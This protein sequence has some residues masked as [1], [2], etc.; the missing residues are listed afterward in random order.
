MVRNFSR[1]LMACFLCMALIVTYAIPASVFAEDAASAG[2]SHVSS[3]GE[4]KYFDENGNEVGAND[5]WKV[6]TQAVARP[7][8]GAPD[9]YD[10]TFETTT[11]DGVKKVNA[12]A[13]ASTVLVFDVSSSMEER[14]GGQKRM[15]AAK[16]AA[17]NFLESFVSGAEQSQRL[18]QIVVFGTN[19]KVLTGSWINANNNGTVSAEA[20]AAIDAVDTEFTY[21]LQT[22]TTDETYIETRKD[23]KIGEKT[24]WRCSDSNCSNHNWHDGDVPEYCTHTVDDATFT[25]HS[26]GFLNMGTRYKCDY[27]GED[28][29]DKSEK[30]S[31]HHYRDVQVQTI[32]TQVVDVKENQWRCTFDGCPYNEWQSGDPDED[33]YWDWGWEYYYTHTHEIPVYSTYYDT[34]GTN[35]EGGLTLA[36][37]LIKTGLD[38]QAL[39]GSSS[40]IVITDGQPTN[41]NYKKN[42]DYSSTLILGEP[43][44]GEC[45]NECDVKNIPNLVKEIQDMNS[46]NVYATVY[47]YDSKLKVY[48][49]DAWQF[50]WWE[51]DPIKTYNSVANWL[52]ETGVDGAYSAANAGQLNEKFRNITSEIEE[53][54]PTSAV[55]ASA[56][57]DN[58]VKY[59]S[60]TGVTTAVDA[61]SRKTLVN[62]APVEGTVN[63]DKSKTYTATF[64]V[65]LNTKAENFPE[66]TNIPVASG[67]SL[68]F[69]YGTDNVVRTVSIDMPEFT[70]TIPEVAYSIEYYKMSKTTGE[71]ELVERDTDTGN[72]K[73][74]TTINVPEGYATKYDNAN[75][76][77]YELA[78]AKDMPEGAAN[79]IDLKLTEGTNKLTLYYTPIKTDVT[80][81][82]YYTTKNTDKNNNITVTENVK[83]A[84]S[85]K[86]AGTFYVGDSFTATEQTSYNG[87]PYTKKSG[88]ATIS[89]L[90][91]NGNEI[92]LYYTGEK[93]DR[94]EASFIG[95]A[96]YDLGQYVVNKTT[97]RY[98]IIYPAAQAQE[99]YNQKKMHAYDTATF[100]LVEHGKE[101]YT[102]AKTVNATSDVTV[103]AAGT[104]LTM[105]MVAGENTMTAVFHKAPVDNRT[106]ASV[107]VVHHYELHETKIVD[108]EVVNTTYKDQG[109]NKVEWLQGY[110]VGEFFTPEE[111]LTYDGGEGNGTV[112]YTAAPGNAAKL[113]STE[114]KTSDAVVDLYYTANVAPATTTVTVEHRY[115]DKVWATDAETGENEK[116]DRENESLAKTVNF[117]AEGVL[118]V[119]YK[120]T[121]P[122]IGEAGY[123]VEAGHHELVLAAGDDNKIVINYYKDSDERA[124]SDMKVQHIYINHNTAVKDG[125]VQVIDITS[126]A[127]YNEA[128]DYYTGKNKD[129]Y[130]V[131]PVTTYDGETYSLTKVGDDKYTGE[132]MLKGKFKPGTN[133][134]I[135]LTYER[136]SSSLVEGVL[137]IW[138]NLIDKFGYI[139]DD[140]KYAY[141]YY[142]GTNAED[143]SRHYSDEMVASHIITAKGI[144]VFRPGETTAIDVPAKVYV[145][146]QFTPDLPETYEYEGTTY[147]YLGGQSTFTAEPALRMVRSVDGDAT[148]ADDANIIRYGYTDDLGQKDITIVKHFKTTTYDVA[149]EVSVSNTSTTA[150]CGG[151]YEGQYATV[152][153]SAE[154][155]ERK[156]DQTTYTENL[157][158][159]IADGN[160]MNVTL[161][162]AAGEG[163]AQVDFYYEKTVDNSKK[164]SGTVTHHYIEVDWDG[165]QAEV[166]VDGNEP[167]SIDSYATRSYSA[168]QKDNGFTDGFKAFAG[169]SELA[170]L[171]ITLAE[172]DANNLDLYYYKNVDNRVATRV[173]V[174]HTYYRKDISALNEGISEEPG[175]D[176]EEGD[177]SL[178]ARTVEVAG[179]EQGAWVGNSFTATLVKNFGR[180][181]YDVIEPSEDPDAEHASDPYTNVILGEEDNIININYVHEYDARYDHT[182]TI[183]HRYWKSAADISNPESEPNEEYSLSCEFGNNNGG[184]WSEEGTLFTAEARNISGYNRV[185]SDAEMTVDYSTDG[186]DWFVEVN[187]VKKHKRPNIP[188]GNDDPGNG[189]RGT[190]ISDG[191]V[192]LSD[193][194]TDDIPDD[195]VPLSDLPG[196]TEE[197]EMIPDEEV[198]LADL[199]VTGGMGVGLF[200]LAGGAIAA[201]GFGLRRREE[202]K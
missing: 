68:N 174:I 88:N 78:A 136:E 49:D 6:K 134:T 60:G 132:N 157:T 182:I 92:N 103:N 64:R 98:E 144:K 18:V 169:D 47:A 184:S 2:T 53:E 186:F 149:H 63:S 120:F 100:D 77:W 168:T 37:N 121:A 192:P 190:D 145:G 8:A 4:V 43:D 142:D 183:F 24:H 123:T 61:E 96:R 106:P 21:Q 155:F 44:A 38:A 11:K 13:D 176:A 143:G 87:I 65:Q 17:K 119:G 76:G 161:N 126:E 159:G 75:G 83:G 7:V 158:L 201:A 79:V 31:H 9:T 1:R 152:D 57:L 195:E 175:Q 137:K 125:I 187:Y 59:V 127:Q 177:M 5:A 167:D 58:F 104:A 3:Q 19:A 180:F 202:E 193:L 164:A 117:P 191:D 156:A 185:T 94:A 197:E 139:T 14:D 35:L 85:G 62:W 15:D 196:G 111:T 84:N 135:V 171:T 30:N 110:Y 198:P 41:W 55:T 116:F 48:D 162:S 170:S 90:A 154:G 151:I 93:D 153:I 109:Y 80:V 150:V 67:V 107:R 146:E 128:T 200:I 130:K 71:Y 115:I 172:G 26:G 108:G 39:K 129:D 81:N 105:P 131:A 95:Y 32:E 70:G 138:F 189:G 46:T 86:V 118:Y 82:Y 34:G 165:T 114:I 122:E 166:S 45:A 72:A 160:S 69:K 20:L 74:H 23:V 12:A 89:S 27:C 112:T 179:I 99:V 140:N 56:A 101:G 42:N 28:G 52:S 33:R 124:A 148:V 147:T 36:R 51:S 188:G 40:V 16:T 199:P 194:P 29:M 50:L 25:S 66:N 22:G 133:D 163:P 102:Y 113:V 178:A 91:K 10:I 181:E 97:G 173:T 141:H 54:L 73:L